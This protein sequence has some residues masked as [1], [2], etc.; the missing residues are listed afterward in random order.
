MHRS[1][2]RA[3]YL[4]AALI[5]AGPALATDPA[6]CAPVGKADLGGTDIVLTNTTAEAI[7]TALGYQPTQ[8]LLGM[9][10]SHVSMRS[11]EIDIFQG[12]WRPV[13]KEQY[14]N[15]LDDGSVKVPG[16]TLTGATFTIAVPQYVADA[17]VKTFADL[18][19]RNIVQSSEA[20]RL[21]CKCYA[22]ECPNLAKFFS[23]LVFDLDCENIGLQKSWAMACLPPK[24]RPRCSPRAP[25]C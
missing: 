7:L 21:S 15:L 6:T 20:G 8:T 19:E 5:A 17:G 22:L 14:Q 10:V 25:H 1:T 12:N 11:G 4:S 24:P 3:L 9:D 2:L 13:Q 16:Q 23:Q 18:G